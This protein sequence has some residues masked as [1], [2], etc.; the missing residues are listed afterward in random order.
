MVL[1]KGATVRLSREVAKEKREIPIWE[2]REQS[3]LDFCGWL[4]KSHRI[5]SPE[6]GFAETAPK[7][8]FRKRIA[9]R[10]HFLFGTKA[11]KV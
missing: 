5:R 7:K 6:R 10:S 3:V 4:P 11:L 2:I 1:E 8:L 9:T